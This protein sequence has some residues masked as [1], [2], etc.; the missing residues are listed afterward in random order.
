MMRR[1]FLSQFVGITSAHLLGRSR[2]F[3]FA[4]ED[5]AATT[6]ARLRLSVAESGPYRKDPTDIIQTRFDLYKRLGF[7]T[8]R[9]SFE[10][11]EVE[12]IEGR[13]QEPP[14]VRSYLKQ[15]I[16]TGFR[17]KL[18][19][20]TLG[21]PPQWYLDAHPDAK[22]CDAAGEF[23]KNDLSLWYPGL[24]AVLA[25]K[26]DRLFNCLFQ[27]DLFEAVDAI[28][29]D[30]GPAGEPVYPA[31]WTM[32][33]S[34]GRVTTPWFYDDH[35]QVD[36]R[37][38][39]E[40]KYGS[41]AAANRVWQT[42]FS[43][44]TAVRTPLPGEWPGVIWEDVLTWYRDS[45]RSFIRWQVENYRRAL[46][47]YAGGCAIGLIIMIP[48]SHLVPEEWRQAAQ[49][50]RPDYSLM[51][52]TDSEFLMDLAKE[53]GCTLQYTAVQ[54]EEEVHYLL[55]YMKDHHINQSLWGENA[56]VDAVAKNPDHLADVV[57][58]N[59]LYG[60]EY[61][62]S[63]YVFGSDHVSPNETFRELGG[64]CQRLYRAFAG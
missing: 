1:K 18:T 41:P 14:Y 53:T 43:N 62:N 31:T 26:T 48:G 21:G 63:S 46:A 59:D 13:W 52:M 61:V 34:N 2:S 44:W 57:I 47:T 60:F 38:S 36:F 49:S 10:W 9:T 39:M 15:A 6:A 64:A 16:T 24:R 11:R 4:S 58:R 27:L 28:F 12:I 35:A 30:L 22:I 37:Q 20:A 7:G 3:A 56:G 45:K 29:V 17:L 25:E 8:L 23:S 55:Q 19:V 50:G 33:K 42:N 40:R 54:N 51:I 32:G 5:P